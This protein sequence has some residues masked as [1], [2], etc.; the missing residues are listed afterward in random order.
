MRI[1]R[2]LTLIGVV[3]LLA[4][5]QSKA[6]LLTLQ[7][8]QLPDF[9]VGNMT[10]QY[11]ASSGIFTVT[12]SADDLPGTYFDTLNNE[13][14][15][16]GADFNL[17]AYVT[18]AGNLTNGTLTIAGDLYDDN[19]YTDLLTG[20]L[21]TGAE[22]TAFGATNDVYTAT[23]FNFVFTITGGTLASD[24]GGVNAPDGYFVLYPDGGSTFSGSWTSDFADHPGNGYGDVKAIPE[25][26]SFVLLMFA[27][28]LG[29]A[30]NI[31]R[32]PRRR[33]S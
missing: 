17:T 8:N 6:Q 22:G 18:S 12:A 28:T 14:D 3:S 25:P 24:Y 19:G 7:P 20:T 9:S 33:D 29:A 5:S 13:T 1:A 26:S 2:V 4:N 23:A 31:L 27:G 10:V 21:A 15:Y 16:I 11:A 32:R 30:A